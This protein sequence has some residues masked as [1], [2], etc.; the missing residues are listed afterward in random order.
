MTFTFLTDYPLGKKATYKVM[1]II[2]KYHLDYQELQKKIF[3]NKWKR[4]DSESVKMWPI[5]L[6]K[7]VPHH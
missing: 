6:H 7:G 4:F 2:K 3:N 5:I 1:Y